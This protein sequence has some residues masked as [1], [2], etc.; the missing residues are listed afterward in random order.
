MPEWAA[1]LESSA[2]SLARMIVAYIVSVTLAVMLGSWMARSRTVERVL[3]PILDILQSIPILGFFPAALLLFA[4]L[5]P[6]AAGLELAAIFLITTSLVWNMIFG[7]YASIKALDPSLFEMT[8][9]YRL[10]SAARFFYVYVPACRASL[11]ANSLVSWAGGWFFLTSAEVLSLGEAEYRLKGIGSFIL[12]SFSRGD[13]ENLY[14][15]IVMLVTVILATY[16]LVWNPAAAATLNLPLLGSRSVYKYVHLAVSS[17][18]RGLTWA[19]LFLEARL[20]KAAIP[21]LARKVL[22]AFLAGAVLLAL[23]RSYQPLPVE[24][25]LETLAEFPFELLVSVTRVAAILLISVTFSLGV[26]YLAHVKPF[27]SQFVSLAGELLASVPAVVWWPL[28]S[29]IAL[30]FAWGPYAVMMVVL[31]Q[32]AFW[33]LYFNLL[34]YGLASVRQDLAEM[35]AVYRLRGAVYFRYFFVPSLLPSLATGA[36]SAWGGAWN[37]S[38]VAE[39]ISAGSMV[40]DMGGVGSMISR[41]AE[42]GDSLGLVLTSLSLSLFIVFVN[43]TLWARIFRFIEKRYGGE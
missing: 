10:G 40:F 42:R 31:L 11:V 27:F 5:L 30:S 24:R 29:G 37:A 7:V 39:Y 36:L 35:A 22:G 9:V 21:G 26:A 14:A 3:L 33:Y 18:W 17:L 20:P 19:A 43:K 16:A 8:R 13:Q 25:A 32:G 12:E 2:L 28:L 4:R 15:G 1:L 6:G 41:L 34:I 38:I 23:L